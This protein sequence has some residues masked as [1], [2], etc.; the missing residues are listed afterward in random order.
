MR[1]RNQDAILTVQTTTGVFTGLPIVLKSDQEHGYAWAELCFH[2]WTAFP[3][4]S[5]NV[6]FFLALLLPLRVLML[7]TAASRFICLQQAS[8]PDLWS[9]FSLS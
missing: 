4:F 1:L 2:F 8:S 6:L 9:L 7:V 3:P 5:R